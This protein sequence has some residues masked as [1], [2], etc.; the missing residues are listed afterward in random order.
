[1]KK[2]IAK[3]ERYKKLVA[4][5]EPFRKK[6][7]RGV[8]LA[9][10]IVFVFTSVDFTAFAAE[11]MPG[12]QS[13]FY[14]INATANTNDSIPLKRISGSGEAF[15]YH[16]FVETPTFTA[17]QTY[18]FLSRKCGN[19][20][21]VSALGSGA[22]LKATNKTNNCLKYMS[23][24][25]DNPTVAV[26]VEVV[27]PGNDFDSCTIGGLY[28]VPNTQNPTEYRYFCGYGG[29]QK[30]G[31]YYAY[32]YVKESIKSTSVSASLNDI[33]KQSS[34]N[35]GDYT[36]TITYNGGRKTVLDSGS[37]TV[38]FT[39]PDTVTFVIYDSEGNSITVNFQSP[40]AVRYEGNAKNA[41]GVPSTQAAWKNGSYNISSQKPTRSG[42][43]FVN[44]K[45]AGTGASYSAGQGFTARQSL[46]LLAQ[47]RDTQ[48]PNFNYAPTRVMTS[49]SDD[50]IKSLIKSALTIT[51]NEPVSECT[52]DITLP[53]EFNKTPGNKD[54]TVKVTDKAGN[55]TTK[56]CS[57]FVDSFVDIAA[58]VFTKGSKNISAVLKGPGVEPIT[59]SGFVWGVIN[60]PSLTLNNGRAKMT[61]PVRKVGDIISVTANNLQ[62]GVVYN[63]RA[64]IIAGG[65]TYYSEETL[66]GLD[67]PD[68]GKFTISNNG[69]NT[70]TVT[71]TG[72]SEGTQTV[73]YRTVNGS[74]VGGTHFTHKDGTLTFNPG[75]TSLPIVIPE[76]NA[77]T[78]YSGKPATAYSNADR[79]YSVEIYKVTGGATLGST[80]SA[81]RTM[82]TGSAYT[83]D[84]N[85]YTTESSSGKVTPPSTRHWAC[86]HWWGS[87]GD[88]WF[89]SD[90]EDNRNSNPPTDNYNFSYRPVFT[91]YLENTMT[92]W[93]FRYNMNTY[94]RDDGWEH[95]WVGRTPPTSKGAENNNVAPNGAAIPLD[96]SVGIA[97]FT[98]S[99]EL[100]ESNYMTVNVPQAGCNQRD[101]YG[102]LYKTNGTMKA[103]G[104]KNYIRLGSVET[105]YCYFAANGKG[106]DTWYINDHTS[107][108]L[109]DDTRE[110][111]LVAVAP[112]AGGTYKVGDSFT[113]SLIFDEIVD[114]TNSGNLST[115]KV[116]TTWGEASYVGGVD[117][118]VLYFEGKIKEPS[119]SKLSV[120]SF[121]NTGIIK[122]MC[123][124]GETTATKSAG[125]STTAT[126]DT[127]KPNFKVTAN[128]SITNGIGT[129]TIK[130]EADTAKTTGMSYVWTDSASMPVKGWVE[131]SAAE[132]SSAKGA[133]LP[134]SIR[135]APGSGASNGK[136]YLHVN[137]I[138]ET[139][140][141]SEYK[142]ACVNFGTESAPETGSTAPSLTVTV[143]NTKWA[144]QREI[145]FSA[146]GAEE[147][148]YR[149]PGST[150]WETISK[151]AKGIF[152]YENGN[153]SFL[154]T[155]GDYSITKNVLVEKI[156]TVN[157]T[158]SVGELASDSVESLKSGVY[159]KI[160]LPIT[161][162]DAQ[163]GVNKVSYSW[164]NSATTPN[165]WRTLSAGAAAVT[166]TATESTP[167]K[168]YLHIMVQDN[169]NNV[170]T[171]CSE[172]YTVISQSAVDSHAPTIT[173]TGAPTKWTN[174]MATLTWELAN[175]SGKQYEV[176]LPNGRTS[177]DSSGNAWARN[178]NSYTVTVRDLDYGGENS[179]SITVDKLDFDAPTVTVSG[180]SDNWTNTNQTF[181]IAASD[182]QSGVGEKWYKIV[183]SKDEIPSEGLTKLSGNTITVSEDGEYYVYYK[184]YDK[185]GDT[186]AS[187]EA[188]KT[189][190]FKLV[191]IDK[192]EPVIGEL[193]YSYTPTNLWEQMV[194]KDS[195]T[196]TV[197]VTEN[198][199]GADEIS[200]TVTPEG[201]SAQNK[202]A[203]ITD[204]SAEITVA[205]DFKGTISI[206]C[207]DK[208]GN[209][210]SSV[211]VGTSDK[212]LILED[213]APEITFGQYSAD[214]GMTVTVEDDKN[215][216]ITA[217]LA[218]VTYKIG[219]GEETDVQED[220]ADSMKTETTFTI[221]AAEIPNG[222]ASIK[223]KAK[224]HAGNETEQTKTIAKYNV[225]YDYGTNGG[226]S[227]DSATKI[228]DVVLSGDNV[229]LTPKAKKDDWEFVGWNTDMNAETGLPSLEMGMEDVTLYA[230]YKKTLTLT[231]YSGSANDTQTATVTIYNKAT[232]GS[233]TVPGAQAWSATDES[234]D[235]CHYVTSQDGFTGTEYEGNSKISLSEN[236]A[237]Y[238]VYRKEIKIAYDANG[239][240]GTDEQ[241]VYKWAH[242]AD[243]VT[244]KTDTFALSDGTGFSR[245][246]YS[247]NGW[248]KGSGEGAV[249]AAETL[250]TPTE[251]T[252]YYASW[253]LNTYT[254]T[255]RAGEGYTVEA[256]D[257]ESPVNYG[258][259]YR[260]CVKVAPGYD[261]S[262]MKVMVNECEVSLNEENEYIINDIAED[263]EVTVTGVA[264]TEAP[265]ITIAM[266]DRTW[267][268]L[269]DS[270]SFDLFLQSGESQNVTI[271]A[272]DKGSGVK[273]VWYHLADEGI[274]A[275]GVEQIDAW[276]EYNAPFS[277]SEGKNYI[278]CVKTE[279][280]AGN[281]SYAN[282][283]GFVLDGTA[284]QIEI[285]GITNKEVCCEGAKVTVT[286]KNLKEVTV[287][288]AS[289]TLDSDNSFMLTEKGE[290]TITVADMAGNESS[291]KVT[292]SAHDFGNWSIT[293]NVSCTE[294]G[295]R[296]GKCSRC[297]QKKTETIP[298]AGHTFPE[299]W[300]VEKEATEKEPGR[301]LKICETCGAKLY[302]TI[303]SL[304]T[305]ANPDAGEIE[306]EV[307]VM[308]GAPDTMLNNS[309]EELAG[310]VL[311]K[312]DIAEI[313]SGTDAKIW[314]EIAP[315]A[316]ISEADKE[317]VQRAAEESV[318][319][320]AEVMY[321]DASLFK[322]VGNGEKTIIHEPGRPISVTI[323][324]PEGIR[325]K[326]VRMVRNYHI[327]RLH[328]GKTDII[329]GKYNE[330]SAEFTFETDKFSTYAICYKDSPKQ[331][332]PGTPTSAP[333][334]T[335][336]PGTPTPVPDESGQSGNEIEKR[337]DLSI[338]L[339]TGKQ[340]GSTG[341]KLTWLKK[342]DASG[343]EVYWS[344]C[345][346]KRNYKK[347]KTV[348][349]KAK[350][351]YTHKKLKKDRAY[352]YYIAAYKIVDGKKK[353]V[354]KSPT[355]HVAMEYE[356]RTNAKKITVNKTKVMLSLT[357]KKYK[358]TFK[359]RV[360]IKKENSK[361]KILT[362][363]AK[364]RYYTDDKKV[365]KVSKTGKITAKGRGKCTLYVI[366]NNGVCKKITVTVK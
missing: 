185:T 292:V 14:Q 325:N 41:G 298:A 302:R 153:Y 347:L 176:V 256:V 3:K 53:S 7:T 352:K 111:K 175:Y 160:V 178:N 182:T 244:C 18:A 336:E 88:I 268:S 76:N 92:G 133:G 52:V 5:C 335:A 349:A 258:D 231:C 146:I 24:C 82:K 164:T 319:A 91:D 287:N 251:D 272:D 79:V 23:W 277:I 221:P 37:Y 350:R 235:F 38:K 211:T 212:G 63:A 84:R 6:F 102:K 262:A 255:L 263:K 276:Q 101:Q 226:V 81:T 161:Y 51:D 203:P 65:V 249:I 9:M 68:Y 137:G 34:E 355:I 190:G 145:N 64:Y 70:F 21:A 94:E 106:W 129:A 314:L 306:K 307:E 366:A 264:D 136:W 260:F 121:S 57:V 132:L 229:D 10:T 69:S 163:S 142:N 191:K 188:N 168:K 291:R 180:G 95:L 59:E 295:E 60:S 224:D 77:N 120:E 247:F 362:H 303:D 177:K 39:T 205:P 279:D 186:A 330:E 195:L 143:D 297:G 152:V 365:A 189:E 240:S 313:D 317:Q 30:C 252:T 74:A 44:W 16:S 326:D 36:V 333:G 320:G 87:E 108:G 173:I 48:K 286:E 216:A 311:T 184:V 331:A 285:A 284:P 73:Y 32:N 328:D 158:A 40:L 8:A 144:V 183:T 267:S 360:K 66:I 134:L 170:Y 97:L 201:A 42:Y 337:K 296:E 49:D 305:P 222:G 338:L 232:E 149:K 90:R 119:N 20:D 225:T 294:S 15:V 266:A 318:G 241:S 61:T 361:K 86:D 1:M 93:L 110:P 135:K 131:L 105:A 280:N 316:D 357:D 50:V 46:R 115:I 187:R 246:G 228:S 283:E 315:D 192:T 140:G 310:S 348:K 96:S 114:S 126:V 202:T 167:T 293:K 329:E 148:K 45:D 301:E 47:W 250:V 154:L 109:P 85:I 341:I 340:K 220:F 117:T 112:M 239:G 147:L 123:D 323:V 141:V 25:Y 11:N 275:N 80:T 227:A 344:Y 162:S 351:T 322:Q 166:Y 215:N 359:L 28:K 346:G 343:Y 19:D 138:Y 181:T 269:L 118:N 26:Y 169:V 281:I 165:M 157:P 234:Y 204:G 208:A 116:K 274:T 150:S 54:V 155:A 238:A 100:K 104:G 196:V 72:G 273:K 300:T 254:V 230:I 22:I 217:G 62:K 107:Y 289:V 282:S 223:V 127:G 353:Y 308:P 55:A 78:A 75:E 35:P 236:T 261:A 174:D 156:D 354:A 159:T 324:I 58:P 206:C 29:A 124:N 99:F 71:R 290:Q 270:L 56:T 219:D 334:G 257:S 309:R 200:Y 125:G 113:V 210:S 278:I 243:T 27:T 312:E 342:K 4:A 130:V 363:A 242:V 172:A 321:F 299:Q 213:N 83:V 259:S 218:S 327:I 358:K 2:Q 103:V 139:T 128:D 89:Y 237:L 364:L 179:A 31:P 197:P 332:T 253:N 265:G 245:T 122:D 43:A 248:I 214:S 17:G 67:L 345:D 198:G 193:S 339:A 98:G 151:A 288:G 271:T 33:D 207:T 194:G 171:T 356:K 12:S 233:L 199:S 304:G 209:T 13:A